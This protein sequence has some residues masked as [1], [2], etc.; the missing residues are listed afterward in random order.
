MN[1]LHEIVSN[2]SAF[3]ELDLIYIYV[4]SCND[5]RDR[6]LFRVAFLGKEISLS[7]LWHRKEFP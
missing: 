7:P 3:L 5:A 2:V 4:N 6:I 1:F